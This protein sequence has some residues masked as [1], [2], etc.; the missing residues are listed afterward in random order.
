MSKLEAQKRNE[1]CDPSCQSCQNDQETKF[2]Q[3]T[4]GGDANVTHEMHQKAGI[5]RWGAKT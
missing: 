5:E 2:D 3:N 4:D 1:P